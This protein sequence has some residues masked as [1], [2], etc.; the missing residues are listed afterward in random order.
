MG[1][2]ILLWFQNIREILGPVFDFIAA[3]ASDITAFT[4]AVIPFLFYWCSDKEEGK[5]SFSK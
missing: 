3:Y 4:A 5:D 2:S 1:I